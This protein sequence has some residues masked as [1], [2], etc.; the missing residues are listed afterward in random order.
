MGKL[1]SQ[2]LRACLENT[3][4]IFRDS[5]IRNS[6]LEAEVLLCEALRVN[7][8]NLYTDKIN[9][10][11]D[12][13]DTIND[14]IKRRLAGEPLAYIVGS[15]V[16]YG[17]EFKV[18]KS[19]LIP[20]AETELL[21]EKVLN[22][23][24]DNGLSKPVIADIGTGCGNI[25][26]SLT[27]QLSSCKIIATDTSGLSLKVAGEN[28]EKYG[29][30][31]KITFSKGDLFK[32]LEDFKEQIDVIVSNPPY[33]SACELN[34]LQREVREEPLLALSG[35]RNGLLFYRKIIKE[36][37][38]F[39]KPLGFLVLELGKGRLEGVNKMLLSAGHYRKTEIFKDYN[40]IDRI[41]VCQK[42]K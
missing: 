23:I 40:G 30:E 4:K 37:Y 3:D 39:L 41:I 36:A 24:K 26:I 21:V 13:L 10:G 8:L 19:V 20:R 35:G 32:P 38:L 29:L 2:T 34:N 17:L 22:V 1:K 11:N 9:L 16:F 15:A 25:A 5:G 18:N 7:K 33:V 31:G 6:R 42:I 12:Q 14:W 28:A 27:K